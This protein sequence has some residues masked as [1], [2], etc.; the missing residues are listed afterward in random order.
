[1][2]SLTRQKTTKDDFERQ[3][4]DFPS[5]VMKYRAF[6]QNFGVELLET[7]WSSANECFHVL[8]VNEPV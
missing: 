2:K 4:T 6:V 3:E 1:M 8:T 7:A 5:C